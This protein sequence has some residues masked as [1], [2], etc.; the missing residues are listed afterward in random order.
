MQRF[1]GVL[2]P[3]TAC[4]DTAPCPPFAQ[5]QNIKAAIVMLCAKGNPLCRKNLCHIKNIAG[6]FSYFND[7]HLIIA[8]HQEKLHSAHLPYLI[9]RLYSIRLVFAIC[10]FAAASILFCTPR[11]KYIFFWK[12]GAVCVF[13][14]TPFQPAEVTNSQLKTNNRILGTLPIL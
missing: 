10:V 5:G 9:E 14:H 1:Q 11:G 13:P 7:S 3:G 12:R 8:L 2:Q 6:L 4:R